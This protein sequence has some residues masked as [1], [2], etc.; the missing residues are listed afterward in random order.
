MTGCFLLERDQVGHHQWAC[1]EVGE[2]VQS[3][4]MLDELWEGWGVEEPF[5]KELVVNTSLSEG[6]NLEEPALFATVF[7]IFVPGLEVEGEEVEQ[8]Y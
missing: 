2:A 3:H 7:L 4:K 8:V 1:F 5:A 6:R